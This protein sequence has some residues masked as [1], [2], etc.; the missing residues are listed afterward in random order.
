MNT[1]HAINRTIAV[2]QRLVHMQ[3]PT[4]SVDYALGEHFF[5]R[6]HEDHQTWYCPNG[7]S[8]HFPQGSSEA[9]KLRAELAQV[10]RQKQW[11]REDANRQREQKLA[12]ERSRAAIKGHMTR[13]KNRIANGVCPVGGCKRSFSNVHEHIRHQHP[14]FVAEHPE[15][16]R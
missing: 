2:E 1:I 12:A 8:L 14:E 9:E 7:H 3:C 4:C 6:R 13:M 15:M 10:K 11:A 5:D 16:V